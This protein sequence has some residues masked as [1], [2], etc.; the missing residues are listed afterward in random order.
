M[1]LIN[2][3]AVSMLLN[4][5][6]PISTSGKIPTYEE[7]FDDCKNAI[8]HCLQERVGSILTNKRV[9]LSSEGVNTETLLKD[10]YIQAYKEGIDDIIKQLKEICN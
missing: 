8:L 1:E 5:G 6:Y 3:A 7:T 2:N 9:S 10:T 4:L